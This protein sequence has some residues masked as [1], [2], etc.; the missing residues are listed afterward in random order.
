MVVEDEDITAQSVDAGRVHRGIL[1]KRRAEEETG[2]FKQAILI[3]LL[4]LPLRCRR[5]PT[6]AESSRMC[7]LLSAACGGLSP[8]LQAESS[9]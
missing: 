6:C 3:I 7:S 1:G 5:V 9:P 2:Y 8:P 4:E